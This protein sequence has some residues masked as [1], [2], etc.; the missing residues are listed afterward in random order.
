MHT[1]SWGRCI[2]RRSWGS[3]GLRS[4][5]GAGV[6]GTGTRLARGPLQH[7]ESGPKA[8]VLWWAGDRPA[9][10]CAPGLGTEGSLTLQKEIKCKIMFKV[11]SRCCWGINA[12][13][14][15]GDGGVDCVG[16]WG[17][18][19][20]DYTLPQKIPKEGLSGG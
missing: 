15:C 16:I 12:R 10:L 17:E 8:V 9:D 1:G 4:K 19:P 18:S 13:L 2:S 7:P 6:G 11:P 5:L 3:L 14:C 20:G